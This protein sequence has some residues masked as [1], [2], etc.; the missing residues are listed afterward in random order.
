MEQLVASGLFA[1]PRLTSL[2]AV[3]EQ[4][5]RLARG[6]VFVDL[7]DAERLAAC[8]RCGPARIERLRRMNL[9]QS[10]LP[11]VPCDCEAAR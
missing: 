5:I 1:P 2:E 9:T 6:R 11:A 8:P 3:L 10:I 4:G 7:W